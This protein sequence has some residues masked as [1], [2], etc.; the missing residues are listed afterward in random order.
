MDKTI[1]IA[2]KE[3]LLYH[4]SVHSSALIEKLNWDSQLVNV[5]RIRDFEV[6]RPKWAVYIICFP[7]GLGTYAENRAE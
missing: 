6:L 4:R 3:L 5:Y 7:Q 1:K 2:P